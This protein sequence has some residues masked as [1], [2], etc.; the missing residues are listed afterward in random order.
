MR[1]T[2]RLSL[3]RYFSVVAIKWVY[4]FVIFYFHTLLFASNEGGSG[5]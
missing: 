2:D 1:I 3:R 4:K 5:G